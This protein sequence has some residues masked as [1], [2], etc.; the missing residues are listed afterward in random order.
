MASARVC[1]DTLEDKVNTSSYLSVPDSFS[2]DE[3][4]LLYEI[5]AKIGDVEGAQR[6]RN[7]TEVRAFS[8]T[9]RAG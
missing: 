4:S 7:F 1:P 5:E 9:A 3:T 6:R 8:R 2:E